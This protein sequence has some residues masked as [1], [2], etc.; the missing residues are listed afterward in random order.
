MELV[1][2]SIEKPSRSRYVYLKPKSKEKLMIIRNVDFSKIVGK[3]SLLTFLDSK[4]ILLGWSFIT[5]KLRFENCKFS[6]FVDLN[7]GYVEFE[8]CIFEIPNKLDQ[9]PGDKV[10]YTKE[11][12]I[13]AYNYIK[14]SNCLFTGKDI[15]P[16]NIGD[17]YPNRNVKV[18]IENCTFDFTSTFYGTKTL[19]SYGAKITIKNSEFNIRNFRSPLFYHDYSYFTIIDSRFSILAHRTKE[20]DIRKYPDSLFKA[21]SNP[22]KTHILFNN[23]E[24]VLRNIR[25]SEEVGKIVCTGDYYVYTKQY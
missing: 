5:R 13:V 19:Y 9:N 11:V 16:V 12:S 8:N 1:N 17:G 6:S 21:C 10:L 4:S 14:F 23:T 3:K 22:A 24:F 20:G 7:V 25:T 15:V 18:Y 2:I